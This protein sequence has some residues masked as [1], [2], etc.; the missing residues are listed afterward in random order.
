MTK[1]EKQKERANRIARNKKLIDMGLRKDNARKP[2][3][4]Q[5]TKSKLEIRTEIVT[6]PITT[7]KRIVVSP[8]K[9]ELTFKNL[10]EARRQE[11][12]NNRTWAEKQVRNI[13]QSKQVK[14]EEEKAF[15]T[16]REKEYFQMA[17]FYIPDWKIVIE[18]DGLYHNEEAQQYRDKKKDEWYRGQ[19]LKVFRITNALVREKRPKWFWK[20]LVGL[21]NSNSGTIK[22]LDAPSK[23]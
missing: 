14:F 7:K 15:I 6:A 22:K 11:R 4:I 18:V 20:Q 21:K 5:P 13:L 9:E 16:D 1:T 23:M 2:K 17:D 8:A 12:L 19:G 10:I 3:Y